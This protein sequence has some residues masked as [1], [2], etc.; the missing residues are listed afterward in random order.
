MKALLKK[1]E[2]GSESLF[3]LSE[4]QSEI[5]NHE[6]ITSYGREILKGIG[7]FTLFQRF[8]AY[9]WPL[10]L[11][12]ASQPESP[13][14]DPITSITLLNSNYRNW[15]TFSNLLSSCS[16]SI[17]P[18]GMI[19][20]SYDRW[21]LEVWLADEKN[22]FRP[23]SQRENVRQKRD[24]ASSI[25]QTEWSSEDCDIRQEIYGARTNIDESILE[26]TC[27]LKKKTKGIRVY[28]VIRPYNSV[29]LGGVQS[30]AF[31]GEKKTIAIN[32]KERIA[33]ND[34]PDTILTGNS[35]RGDCIL[36]GEVSQDSR[37]NCSSGMAAMALGFDLS[38][39]DNVFFIRISLDEDRRIE[40]GKLNFP[41][42][43]KDFIGYYELRSRQAMNLQI[44]DKTLGSWFY[45]LKS[46]TL[47][48]SYRRYPVSQAT[49]RE[50]V[51][52]YF[53]VSALN[54]I[55]YHTESLALIDRMMKKLSSSE[56]LT[57]LET[58][59]ACYYINALSDYF[60][61][62]RNT[63]FLQSQYE[64]I[65]RIAEKVLENS[66]SV[67]SYNTGILKNCNSLYKNITSDSLSYDYI[68]L[69]HSLKQFAY[70]S[71]CIGLFGDEI[72]FTKEGNRIEMM[73]M[74]RFRRLSPGSSIVS[75]PSADIPSENEFHCY[76]IAA[77][78]PFRLE[79]MKSEDNTA[80]LERIV[81]RY[82]DL[83]FYIRSYGGWDMFISLL[84]AINYLMNHNTAVLPFIKK[85]FDL[86]KNR[87]AIPEIVNPITGN[88]ISGDG[89]SGIIS[90]SFFI[91]LRNMVF[92]DHPNRLELFPL[93]Q[94]QWFNP[95]QEITIEHA[96]SRFGEINIR[97]VS[98]PNE[99][100][101]YFNDLPKFI[102]PDIMI[103]LPFSASLKEDEDFV[104]K[105]EAGNSFI[106]NG[107][108]SIIRFIR[109]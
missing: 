92:M 56:K 47:N 90:A 81:T 74:D 9:R 22:L 20:P 1:K 72:R 32:G 103:N 85:L 13:S 14:F 84:T 17:D 61:I 82:D 2:R 43:K 66:G 78:Y 86:G 79:N 80:L 104:I 33:V 7:N 108:P 25:I 95:G 97:T 11:V 89:D 59:D 19:S 68:L 6:K 94:E 41:A 5:V 91:L 36:A 101:I 83:P 73:V 98:T 57:F 39:G 99:L 107:W 42:V 24:M 48:H 31:D 54:R 8:S 4:L 51:A 70:L 109:K 52:D 88:G 23:Q 67:K 60:T 75:I 3:S 77:G 106:I 38:K 28:L 16:L 49:K 34:K 18:A 50:M 87:Y 63:D 12:S 35:E 37:V 10:W 53:I 55:G 102:P 45:A 40:P 21:S 65:K 100:Q 58:I 105:K 29:Q 62:S 76:D 26:I 64:K 96:P 27:S 44:P 15:M 71:R 69:A 93:P 30:I 46:S